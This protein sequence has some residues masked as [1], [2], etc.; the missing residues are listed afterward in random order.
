MNSVSKK[1]VPV[2]LLGLLTSSL[3]YGVIPYTVTSAEGGPVSD[4]IGSVISFAE[5]KLSDTLSFET[6]VISTQQSTRGSVWLRE[7]NNEDRFPR[8]S[9]IAVVKFVVYNNSDKPVDVF[10]LFVKAWFEGSSKL[11]APVVSSEDSPHV[12]LGYP[13]YLIDLFGTSS[14]SWVIP[15][16]ESIVFAESFY[17][18]EGSDLKVSVVTS[19]LGETKK[20]KPVTSEVFTLGI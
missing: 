12:K 8:G 3:L 19:E 11:A 14:D 6:V 18:E 16:G 15:A 10:G 2:A 13:E 1:F 4:V 20:G 7:D 5:A 17:V 9:Q